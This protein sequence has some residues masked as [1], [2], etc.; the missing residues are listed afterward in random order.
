MM[1]SRWAVVLHIADKAACFYPCG[2]NHALVYAVFYSNRSTYIF[3]ADM[4]HIADKATDRSSA[5]NCTRIDYILYR[6]NRGVCLSLNR[7]QYSRSVAIVAGWNITCVKT[8]CDLAAVILNACN[9]T[10]S[11]LISGYIRCI[12]TVFHYKFTLV[13]TDKSADPVCL[14]I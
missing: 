2:S 7:G 1:L 6:P 10:C 13:V 11:M 4:S 12:R 14:Y 3:F 5:F 9:Q 8:I